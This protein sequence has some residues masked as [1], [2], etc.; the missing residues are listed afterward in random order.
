MPRT[1]DLG[2]TTY[3]WVP[4]VAGIAN[5]AAPTAAA[6]TTTLNISN[7]V[8]TTTSVNPTASDTVTEKG[9]T[10]VSNAVVPTVGN[11]EGT[12]VLFRD[13]AAGVPSANDPLTTI[14]ATSGIFG[15]LVRRVGFASTVAAT[16]AQKVDLFLFM[17]DSPQ[18][19]GGQDDGYLKVTIPLLQQ[20]TF[21][22]QVALT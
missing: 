7:Y 17:T 9:I 22:L 13:L 11:Y 4:G 20:G 18:L 1:V 12:L 10:D 2:T 21:K 6:L 3:W 16:A 19:T 15:W 8:V 5:P 14:G